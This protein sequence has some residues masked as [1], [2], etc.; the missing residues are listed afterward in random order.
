MT[1][2]YRRLHRMPMVHHKAYPHEAHLYW[3]YMGKWFRM[4]RQQ[5]FKALDDIVAQMRNIKC[6]K[7]T[8]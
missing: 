2:N 8:S 3:R 4:P 7:S 5:L 6:Q 1:N